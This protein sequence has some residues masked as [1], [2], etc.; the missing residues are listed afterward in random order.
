MTLIN[1]KNPISRKKMKINNLYRSFLVLSIWEKV[2]IM[3]G[4]IGFVLTIY[5]IFVGSRI[6]FNSDTATANLLARE[7]ILSGDFFPKDW[8][9]V[10]D[11]WTFSLN[12]PIVFL[13][14]IIKDQILI[15]SV[16]VLLQTI[17]L[18]LVLIVFSRK[19]LNN[20]SWIIY[21][22][23]LLSGISQYY[24]ENMFGQ[25]TYAN[26][27]IFILL[28]LI[29]GL[30]SIDGNMK[31]NKT[32][33]VI[34]SVLTLITNIG[35]V[36]YLASFLIPFVISVFLVY[37]ID[38]N[39]ITFKEIIKPAYSFIK[40]TFLLFIITICG[41]AI[42]KYITSVGSYKAGISN[43]ALF[44]G[45]DLDSLTGS[46]R[47]VI[48]SFWAL[49]GYDTSVSLFSI[50]GIV[51][52]VKLF[53]MFAFVFVFPLMLTRKYKT[54]NIK[55]KRLILFSWISL[56][57]TVI[58]FIFIQGLG[59]ISS[60]R[61]FQ[62]NIILQIIVSCYY[63][64][65]F[66]LKKNF[67]TCFVSMCALILF[68]GGSQLLFIQMNDNVIAQLKP[69]YDLVESLKNRNLKMGY[70]SYWNA[71]ENSVFADFNPEIVAIIGD[72][73]EPFYH[74]TSKRFYSSEYY[75]G[76]TFL[77]L[78]K[79]EYDWAMKDDKLSKQFGQSI[80]FYIQGDYYIS[81]YNYN[82]AERFVNVDLVRGKKINILPAMV[83]NENVKE[84][85]DFSLSLET[86]GIVYGPYSDLRTG[87]Y[88]LLL[89]YSFKE[90]DKPVKLKITSNAG[91]T[92][93]MEKKV[94][95]GKNAIKFKLKNDM[96]DVE[97]VLANDLPE[98][99]TIKS[100]NIM[101]H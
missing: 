43:P 97:F 65:A 28:M 64:Y 30:L 59:S 39:N 94:H 77:M 62:V 53:G 99:I 100:M 58:L 22:T 27:T 2:M 51:T 44:S 74:L 88:D 101:K 56:A 69:T 70:A 4:I 16:A 78:T 61:Y 32:S 96:Q 14:F 67:L 11:L 66:M 84:N 93:V 25:A 20:N 55:I 86:G 40:W 98:N 18:L 15:R 8:V 41:L 89:N 79:D 26:I 73:I 60:A 37:F 54:L 7:Q 9:Y 76:K 1:D 92:I 38:N 46:S 91:Q 85:E 19:V 95:P 52:M 10:Q 87:E 72:P 5:F 24:N 49:F 33:F 50:N 75:N 90:N 12:I 80:D 63:I 36:R 68:I 29:L 81:I 17:I 42:F 57:I 47:A 34:L 6:L 83:H 23:I 21:C 82:I 48:P 31:I 13:S 35:G 45:Y 3:L 71:Y